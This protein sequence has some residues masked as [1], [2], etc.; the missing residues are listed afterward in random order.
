MYIRSIRD[1]RMISPRL[2]IIGLC[3][4]SCVVPHSQMVDLKLEF[5]LAKVCT[6]V[7]CQRDLLHRNDH[8][9]ESLAH[10]SRTE[11]F[12]V[13]EPNKEMRYGMVAEIAQLRYEQNCTRFIKNSHGHWQQESSFVFAYCHR[14]CGPLHASSSES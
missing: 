14:I 4:L 2:F 10:G 11:L 13:Y 7:Q 1:A 8:I 3:V 5:Q 9:S 6:I 12:Q